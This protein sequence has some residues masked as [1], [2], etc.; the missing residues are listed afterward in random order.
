MRSRSAHT[1]LAA[2]VFAFGAYLPGC[3][4]DGDDAS[5]RQIWMSIAPIQ[6]GGNAWEIEDKT[7]EAYLADLGADVIDLKTSTFAEAVCL[8]C[9][10]PNG[11]RVDILIDKD[12]V[13]ILLT[14]GFVRS[15]DW[16]Y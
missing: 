16:P 13:S 5:D 11:Q 9:S 7:I 15:N 12:D 3:L 14:E 6:C 8:A 4:F 2:A 1:Y 10:C